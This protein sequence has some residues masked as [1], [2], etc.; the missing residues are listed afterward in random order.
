MAKQS[1]NDLPSLLTAKKG[2]RGAAGRLLP[3]LLPKINDVLW[4]SIFLMVFQVG[5]ELMNGD[6]D[7][8]RHI[9]I[10][11]SILDS[12]R[13]PLIDL[14]SHTL[15]GLPLTPH[16]WLSQLIF[17]LFYRW[18]GFP[19][20]IFVAG[21]ILATTFWLVFR[22]SLGQSKS[23]FAAL[24][25]SLMVFLA[26]TIHW[27]SRPH[28]FTFLLLALWFHELLAL[29]ASD[30]PAFKR[31][32]WTL[33][34]IMVLWANLHGAFI[35]GFATAALFAA[36]VVIDRVLKP[37][38]ERQPADGKAFWLAFGVAVAASLLVTLINPSG[39]QLWDTS[40][41]Y[42]GNKYL[43]DMTNE[44][45]SPNFHSTSTWPFLVLIGA[46]VV[47]FALKRQKVS[48][49]QVVV[50]AAWMVMGLYS[51]RN[52]PLFAILF[53]PTLAQ[54]IAEWIQWISEK[55][56]RLEKIWRMDQGMLAI[57]TMLKGALYPALAVVVMAGILASGRGA[58]L[59]SRIT[60]DPEKFPVEAVNWIEAHPMQ[61][62]MYNQFAWGGY[63]L[64]RL[65]P[66]YHVFIDGQT[67]FYGEG[68]TREFAQVMNLEPGWEQ[69]LDKY[70]VS[71][72][73]VPTGEML[74][75]ELNETEG[76][77]AAYEDPTATIFVIER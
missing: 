69:V 44:Y 38:D 8:G 48:A 27:L 11:G 29:R 75:R 25:A 52:I 17:A 19:G 26:S 51:A 36:G 40:V 49:V 7:L 12:G 68:L 39:I 55:V 15:N 57:E 32:W 20:V 54:L 62:N 13:I 56:K 73:I 6:G 28:I 53:A 14:F 47:L 74:A 63:L 35:A 61:G 76:W 1:I 41:G 46:A 31:R 60:Y 71:W 70:D 2:A 22:Q 3:Y 34:L 67:D 18:A 5:R 77:S 59:Y 66:E 10:G 21:M 50:P 23:F 58:A 45:Q 33:P 72:I 30:K 65:W 64:Y 16:E 9:T 4:V 24:I 43:V 42:L 37:N